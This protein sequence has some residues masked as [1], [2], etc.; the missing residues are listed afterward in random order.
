MGGAARGIKSH[1]GNILAVSGGAYSARTVRKTI[2]V[3][4]DLKEQLNDGGERNINL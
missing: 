1:I 4:L 3:C 2:R